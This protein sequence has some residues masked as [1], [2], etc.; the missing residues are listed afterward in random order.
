MNYLKNLKWEMILF[1]L[2]T[3]AIGVL[4]CIYPTKIVT[5]V[6]IV[7]ASIL[8]I[9]GIRCLLEYRRKNAIQDFYKYELVAGIALILGGIVVLFCMHLLLSIITYVIAIIII[10]SGL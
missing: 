8:F 7:L 1:S 9:L 2:A 3:I 10:V 4:M 5:A 6:C